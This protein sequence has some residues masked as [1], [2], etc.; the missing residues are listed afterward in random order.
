[1]NKII[2]LLC[3]VVFS[4]CAAP[5]SNLDYPAV[6]QEQNL[7]CLNDKNDQSTLQLGCVQERRID[8]KGYQKKSSQQKE[9]LL[10]ENLDT[11]QPQGVFRNMALET[12]KEA[13]RVSLYFPSSFKQ[14]VSKTTI[15]I[16]DRNEATIRI[17]FTA[18]TGFRKQVSQ[19]A[20]CVT[21]RS[22]KVLVLNIINK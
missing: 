8:C 7:C 9:V 21:D 2:L 16:T 10:N 5:T 20:Y 4:G 6:K 14:E 1:M 12:C 13:V 11:A 15:K 17:P 19:A 3:C 18:K 22:G